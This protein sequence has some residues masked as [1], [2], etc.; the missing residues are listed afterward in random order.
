MPHRQGQ[1]DTRTGTETKETEDHNLT[2]C[3][4]AP[5]AFDD[6][7]LDWLRSDLAGRERVVAADGR[8]SLTESLGAC[9]DTRAPYADIYIRALLSKSHLQVDRNLRENLCKNPAG[10]KRP[11]ENL[12]ICQRLS[13]KI[14]VRVCMSQY[15]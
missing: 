15:L 2:A 9:S 11:N 10:W 8:R 14:R 1:T 12:G 13:H 3:P 5:F 6:S 4:E 7:V